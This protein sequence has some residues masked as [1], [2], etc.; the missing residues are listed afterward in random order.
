MG[1]C[2]SS[3]CPNPGYATIPGPQ[4]NTFTTGPDSSDNDTKIKRSYQI[5]INGKATE[6]V[7]NHR[8]R[9][10]QN[11]EIRRLIHIAIE[12]K[13]YKSK[14]DL[15]QIVYNVLNANRNTYDPEIQVSLKE[16][17][18]HSNKLGLFVSVV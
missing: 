12:N 7:P 17:V 2:A 4:P 18:K 8:I 6:F 13:Q 11:D 16:V 9:D 1:Q 5:L 10:T 14:N 3:L 15:R